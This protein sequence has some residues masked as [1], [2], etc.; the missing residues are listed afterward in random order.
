MNKDTSKIT[1]AT[2]RA[3]A[4]DSLLDELGDDFR[5][6]VTDGECAEMVEER[7]IS[8]ARRRDFRLAA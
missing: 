2:L 5:D 7:A 4:L 6:F 8:L 3:A 1:W